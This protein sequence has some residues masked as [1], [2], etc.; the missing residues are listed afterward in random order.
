MF[1]Q[2]SQ[3]NTDIN[4]V[5]YLIVFDPVRVAAS[6]R[7]LSGGDVIAGKELRNGEK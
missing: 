3:L 1:K 7:S 4:L 5:V 2:S 6:E